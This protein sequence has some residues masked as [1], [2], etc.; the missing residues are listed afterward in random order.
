MGP[1]S[2]AAAGEDRRLGH[3]RRHQGADYFRVPAQRTWGQRAPVASRRK[4]PVGGDS[5]GEE[6]QDESSIPPQ[7]TIQ[8]P[9]RRS[10]SSIRTRRMP[11]LAPLAGVAAEC[12]NPFTATDTCS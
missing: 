1:Q 6:L 2:G 10:A 12:S 4:S 8:L 5:D 7:S 11:N 3:R 9:S